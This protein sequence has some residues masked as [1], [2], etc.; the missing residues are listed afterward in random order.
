MSTTDFYP[1]NCPPENAECYDGNIYLYI[2]HNPAEPED[3]YTAYEKGTFKRKDPCQRK[4]L[5][6]GIEID[7]LESIKDLFPISGGWFHAKAVIECTDGVLKQTNNNKYHHSLWLE[8][9]IRNIFYKRL[10]VI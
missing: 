2:R 9:S 7:Y 1:D 10:E 8:I 4:S 3:A 6:C 5:S